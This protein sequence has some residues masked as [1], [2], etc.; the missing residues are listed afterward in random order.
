MGIISKMYEPTLYTGWG[1]VDR[2]FCH[3][4]PVNRLLMPRVTKVSV[5]INIII[6][7]QIGIL[8]WHAFF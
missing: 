5:P 4:D 8:K 2:I 3:V 7:S 6:I 1:P